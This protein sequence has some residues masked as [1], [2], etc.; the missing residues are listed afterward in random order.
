MLQLTAG[1]NCVQMKKEEE[2]QIKWFCSCFGVSVQVEKKDSFKT[3]ADGSYLPMLTV[4]LGLHVVLGVN[5]AC[6]SPL[7]D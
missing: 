4:I 2:L 7:M 5:M 6:V 1:F 3:S